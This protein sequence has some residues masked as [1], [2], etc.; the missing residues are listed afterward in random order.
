LHREEILIEKSTELIRKLNSVSQ[1]IA[2][3]KYG[4][5]DTETLFELTSAEEIS[6]DISELAESIGMMLVKVEA[7]EFRLEGT[8]EELRAAKSELEMYSQNLEKM[9][10]QRTEELR[11]ANKELSRL[12]NLDGLTRIAN[13]R[14]FNEYLVSE[15]E[16]LSE[17]QQPLSLILIDVDCFKLFND[18]YGHLGGDECLIKLAEVLESH[19][20][21]SELLAARYGGEEFAVILPETE[22]ETAFKIAEEMRIEFERKEIPHE[23]NKAGEFATIS[24]GISTVVPRDGIRPDNLIES[25]DKALYIAKTDLGRNACRF[26][27]FEV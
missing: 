25:A 14:I 27:E 20:K 5:I 3:G 26:I 23:K 12:A 17:E 6:P 21:G 8:I 10:E 24:V 9:V 4:E 7:R 18:T 22:G 1:A 13:R 11:E 15:W 16:R 2:S 19:T